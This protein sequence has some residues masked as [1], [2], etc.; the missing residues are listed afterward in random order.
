MLAN[1]HV[2]RSLLILGVRGDIRERGSLFHALSALEAPAGR[3]VPSLI[4]HGDLDG[5]VGGNGGVWDQVTHG[6]H[7][8]LPVKDCKLFSLKTIWIFS[9]CQ[10]IRCIY[11]KSKIQQLIVWGRQWNWII[12][13]FHTAFGRIEICVECKSSICCQFDLI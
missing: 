1:G 4:S 11:L 3:K 6:D 8:Q 7:C 12:L 9:F 2:Q 5:E 10:L 13:W